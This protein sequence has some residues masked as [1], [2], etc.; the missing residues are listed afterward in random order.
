VTA[1]AIRSVAYEDGYYDRK[2]TQPSPLPTNSVDALMGTVETKAAPIIARVRSAP[3]LNL[4]PE[5]LEYL[6]WFVALLA[7]RTPVSRQGII[8]LHE[9][10]EDRELRQSA[11]DR[12][13]F[14][15]QA[16]TLLRANE[17][18]PARQSLLN[19]DVTLNYV[20]GGE[21]EDY[22]MAH[23]LELAT[24][25]HD[26]LQQRH[27]H[28]AVTQSAKSFLITDNPLVLLPS[29]EHHKGMPVGY[30]NG[31]SLLP[32]SPQRALLIANHP[33]SNDVLR[34]PREQMEQWQW[35]TITRCYKTL[36]SHVDSRAFQ[37]LLDSTT[38]GDII[39]V[40]L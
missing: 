19:G 2:S 11:S 10:L 23:Q 5:E 37:K 28:L 30:A 33:L 6:S 24:V 13:R 20:R 34:I 8:N 38:E 32:I 35:Y 1:K 26:I 25:V 3:N 15:Q 18:E 39:K 27:W 22:F 21:T 7:F 12:E 36:F 29:P 31:W 17:I 40:Q 9:A 16:A 14:H 4:S